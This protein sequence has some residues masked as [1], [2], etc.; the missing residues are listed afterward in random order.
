V[1]WEREGRVS[2]DAAL[3]FGALVSAGLWG[4]PFLRAV[5]RQLARLLGLVRVRRRG[6]PVA[7][8]DATAGAGPKALP[9]DVSQPE[10]VRARISRRV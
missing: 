4:Q 7:R 6:A 9:P 5:T 2:V 10:T 8:P 1:Y 3:L